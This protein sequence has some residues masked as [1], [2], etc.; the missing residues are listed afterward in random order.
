MLTP[1]NKLKGINCVTRLINLCLVCFIVFLYPSNSLAELAPED[2]NYMTEN[3]SPFNYKEDGKITG[4]SVELLKL[5]WQEMGVTPQE[6]RMLP[7]AR[8][9]LKLKSDRH[10][11][12][13]TTGRADYREHLFKWVCPITRGSKQVLFAKKNRNIKIASLDDSKKYVIGT[14]IDDSAEQTLLKNGYKISEL[15]RVS[16]ITQNVHKLKLNRIDLIAQDDSTIINA[17]IDNNI[18]PKKYETVYIIK[19]IESCFAFNKSVPNK[20]INRFQS[21]LDNVRETEEYRGIRKK[22]GFK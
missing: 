11:M 20:L 4:F 9:Y 8:A 7:W 13:F 1:I 16:S 10:G 22:Y 2:L 15:K 21:A 19:K 17:M 3:I 14:V 6:I 5:V 18:D 12:L